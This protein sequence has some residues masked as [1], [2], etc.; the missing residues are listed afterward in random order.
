MLRDLSYRFRALLRRNSLEAELDEELRAHIEQ[1]AEKYVQE[2]MSPQEAAR[3]ARLEFG[4]VE[5]VKEECRE[6]WGVWFVTELAQD[7][8]YG[9]R[10]L[11]RNP[12]FT[13]VA[14]LTLALGIGATTAVF[15]LLDAVLFRPLPYS[16][17]EQLFR[18]YP[19]DKSG[20]Y[21]MEAASY[22]DFED[23]EEQSRTFEAIAAYYQQDFNLTGTTL[24]ERLRGLCSTPGLFALLGVNPL[25][26]REFSP[27][28][29]PHV[30]LLS[31][32][33]W[34]R[35]FAGDPS[36]LGK[37][38]HLDGWAY[39]VMGV[40]PQQFYFPPQMFEGELTAEV[41]V[42]AVPNPGRGWNYVRA[43]GR[44]AP[45]VTVLQAQTEMN[46][47]AGRLA[48]AYPKVD[49]GQRIAF[50]R[51][52]RVAVSGMRE[53]AWMLFVAVAFV[54]LIA[55]A[56][57]ANLLLA[58]GTA[59]EHEIA[60]RRIVG[61]TRSRLMRQLLTESLLLAILGG[62]SGVA[63]ANWMLPLVSYLVPQ[64][65]MFYTRIHDVGIH[66]NDSVLLFGAF[67]VALSATLFGVLPAW[68]VSRDAHSRGTT[69]R[70]GRIRGALIGLEIA[71]SIVL[72]A[73]A[74]LMM[75][76]LIRLRSVDVGFRT[77]RL[78]T[79]D[80]S[81]PTKK[82]GSP[83]KQAAFFEH[84]LEQVGSLPSVLSAGAV[85]DLPLTRSATWNYF[86]IP[87][88]HPR[89]GV[90]GYHAISP[91]YFRTMGIPLLSG[92]EQKESDSA[93]SP[94]VGVISWRMAQE[95]WPNQ[96]PVGASI[97]VERAVVT[98][99]PN[100]NSVQF[101]PQQLEIV[102]VVGNVRQLGLDTPPDPELYIP[103]SQ[104]PSDEMSLVLRTKSE[105]SSLIPTVEKAIWSVDS[106]Q[107]VTS[108]R[109]MDQWV[110]KEAASRRFVLQLIGVF[111]LVAI[112]LAAVGL[113]GVVS[114]WTRHRTHEIGIR[115]A[116]GA[117]KN[118]VLR[119]VVGQGLKL[120]LIGVA[121]GVAGA[122]ALTRF[123]TSLL[124]GVKPTDP[125]TFIAVS[126]ILIAVALLACYI[127]AR[128]AAKVDPMVAL[129]YE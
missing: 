42:P 112:A 51:L 49:H 11:R 13:I 86:E 37:P 10:Q 12:G 21:T 102:G 57:E 38:I 55:C 93:D 104:W 105:P 40:L 1:Q 32:R 79:L 18:L 66:L 122:L 8:R 129:R 124:Y 64:N 114:Y 81:L 59:R 94:L 39:T 115:M 78:L 2:G 26:G 56:N 118:E 125:L 43:I 24:P 73:G 83:E 69:L 119:M 70:I 108:V 97:V 9:L 3:R 20:R 62:A 72:L 75:R 106:D 60:V 74:G 80:I 107:P 28:D 31:Y 25:L 58:R 33:L 101:K 96:N 54:L 65:T 52:D 87:G 109:T 34:Q 126:L 121:I 48:H 98:S 5:Q 77:H 46:G 41:F 23:W 6:S 117:Q 88:T 89:R 103:Y 111:A 95:Y 4:G 120:A 68:R 92:R 17:S 67:L 16:N 61:A 50:G 53:T 63:L 29:G 76:S 15:S 36:V 27:S 44:L 45:G 22:P 30:A 19:T 85:T 82:Y 99:T 128:H 71:L 113:Y 91:D 110:S 7:L 127:P 35:R 14:V 84:V 100:G 116:L 90:A 123:L 47:I